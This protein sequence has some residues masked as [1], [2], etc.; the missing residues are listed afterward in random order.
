M[1]VNEIEFWVLVMKHFRKNIFLFLILGIWGLWLPSFTALAA[2]KP[3]E[4]SFF[5][6][7]SMDERGREEILGE[8]SYRSQRA[9]FIVDQEWKNELSP[10]EQEKNETFLQSL[11]A[12]FDEKI[13]PGL[14]SVYGSEWRPGLDNDLRLTILF[15]PLQEG[16]GG[17]FRPLDEQEKL[18]S[19]SSNEREM[20]YLNANYLPSNYVRSLLAHELTHLLTYN[21]KNRKMR[22]VE[23]IWLNEA[24]AEYTP[25]LLGYDQIYEGSNLQRRAKLFLSYPNDSLVEWQEEQADY[26]ALNIF[27]QY[28]VEHY[29]IE[30]LVDSLHSSQ[31]GIAALNEALEK[32]NWAVNFSDVFTDWTIASY[33][34][35]CQIDARYCYL[36]SAL[37]NLRVTPKTY[38]L[39]LTGKSSLSSTDQTKHWAGK[40]IRFIGGE[41]DLTL[42]F[43]GS[44][45]N[46]FQLPYV[47]E[48]KNGEINTAFLELD[49]SQ[50]GRL[51]VPNFGSEVN[52]LTIIPSV[53][54]KVSGFNG[55]ETPYAFFWEVT[56]NPTA[57]EERKKEELQQTISQLKVQIENLR[58]QL[59]CLL[60]A[61]EGMVWQPWEN[62]LS[63]GQ[64]EEEE[65]R[66]LQVFLRA[67]GEEIYS[68]GLVTGNFLAL[69][70]EAV[71]RF[72]EKYSGE[73]LQPLG[74]AQGTG[75]F[76]PRTRE[77]ANALLSSC[78]QDD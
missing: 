22:A 77:K 78:S 40:W 57:V 46:L 48:M 2:E 23:E 5:V 30:I 44:S 64:G 8:L 37:Q 62:N 13:Y 31:T 65:V 32:N 17:Y 41:G 35:D 18:Q 70:Q 16:S 61:R 52:S 74:L 63:F 11:G 20:V 49:T 69:T 66:A 68:A 4:V 55:R 42:R 19:P 14:T 76:G 38:F 12:E 3:E 53:Q 15:H 29:G 10:E 75:I 1:I 7:S 59:A 28:L 25:T 54:S 51:E 26:G 43:I 56:T 24:R 50:Q 72:Q 27:T 71:K 21:Q 34:N 67:Q 58:A 73:I 6:D 33:L 47:L 39:P 45:E 9:Y 60:M 36:D